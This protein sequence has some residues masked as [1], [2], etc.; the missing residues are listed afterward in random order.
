MEIG[1]GQVGGGVH[2][3]SP[4]MSLKAQEPRKLVSETREDGHIS[5]SRRNSPFLSLFVLFRTSMD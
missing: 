3:V 2:G 4:E 1:D 5:S